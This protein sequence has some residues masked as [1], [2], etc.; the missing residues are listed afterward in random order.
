MAPDDRICDIITEHAASGQQ[1]VLNM[2]D[3]TTRHFPPGSVGNSWELGAFL[4]LNVGGTVR[5]Y[6]REEIESVG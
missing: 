2:R 3:G 1:V 4:F 6:R 5:V